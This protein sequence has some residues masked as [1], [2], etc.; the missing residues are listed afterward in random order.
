MGKHKKSVHL[1]SDPLNFGDTYHYVSYKKDRNVYPISSDLLHRTKQYLPK[2][3]INGNTLLCVKCRGSLSC[4]VIEAEKQFQL[5][6][7]HTRGHL[8]PT[9]PENCNVTKESEHLY[10]FLPVS[11]EQVKAPVTQVAKANLGQTSK[12]TDN[13]TSHNKKKLL[14]VPEVAVAALSIANPNV[15]TSKSDRFGVPI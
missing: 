14:L 13:A 1:C 7:P 11:Q 5:S 10:P 3:R 6:H 9:L 2:V 12:L 8:Y 15:S 4:K